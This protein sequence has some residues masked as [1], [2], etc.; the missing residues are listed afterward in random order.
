[1]SKPRARKSL[2]NRWFGNSTSLA[3]LQI[4][5]LLVVATALLIPGARP[6]PFVADTN[7]LLLWFA[8]AAGLLLLPVALIQNLA[9]RRLSVVAQ[10]VTISSLMLVFTL[11]TGLLLNHPAAMFFVS[12][13]V[14]NAALRVSGNPLF[15]ITVLA[16]ACWL[17]LWHAVAAPLTPESFPGALAGTLPLILI[18]WVVRHQRED[19]EQARSRLT[20][21]SYQDELTGTLNMRAFSRLLMS[22]HASAEQAGSGYALLMVDIENLQELNERYGH[23]QGNRAINAVADALKRSVRSDDF[24]ARYGGDEFIVYLAGAGEEA[25]QAVANRISQNVFNITLSFERRT[26]RIEVNTGTAVYPAN[27]TSVQAMMSYAD[28][29]MYREKSFRQ[30]VKTSRGNP[31]ETRRQAGVEDELV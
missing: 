26:R 25:A 29:D 24:I 1:M 18:A 10:A 3:P 4:C 13:A 19:N 16:G 14:V 2:R 5:L 17:G 30:R 9:A 7:T 27:G 12:F 21:L 23:E 31:D 8:I 22:A 28:K 15:G 11:A 6:R 20:A